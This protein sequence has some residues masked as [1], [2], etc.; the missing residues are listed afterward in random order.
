M[1]EKAL[2]EMDDDALT[3]RGMT[4][5]SFAEDCHE[6]VVPGTSYCEKHAHLEMPKPQPREKDAKGMPIT[7][8]QRRAKIREKAEKFVSEGDMVR[9]QMLTDTLESVKPKDGEYTIVKRELNDGTT[10]YI[11][12]IKLSDVKSRPMKWVW[13][14]RI[15]QGKGVVI[16]GQP[17][18]G[19]SMAV[20]DFM[21]RIT[22]GDDWPDGAKNE[23]GAKYVVWA[24][25]EDD[26]ED[27]VK[28]R[29][30]ALGADMS[31]ITAIKR[32]VTS[33]GTLHARRL[34]LK[35]DI[36]TLYK[37]LNENPDI[38][39][40]V[41][42]P[43]TGFYGG[44][45]GNSS[46]EIRPIMEQL[47]EVCRNT[48]VTIMAIMHE[49]RRKDVSAMERILGSGAVGQVFRAAFRFSADP[50]NKGGYIMA[51]SKTNYKVKGGLRYTIQDC[52]VKLDTGEEVTDIGKVVWGEQHELS[53]DDVLQQATEEAQASSAGEDLTFVQKAKLIF[54]AE[55]N[56]GR[57]P[58]R[59]IHAIFD[60]EGIDANVRKRA[61]WE[62]GVVTIG[63]A[64]G[65]Y[66]WAL[67]GKDH[68]I[69]H[70]PEVKI[71][72]P[73]LDEEL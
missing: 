57:R 52:G 55:L 11:V 71:P 41:F 22:K 46:K 1:S 28:P 29:L 70:P 35:N 8:N 43:I 62:L 37:M 14:G 6:P 2:R 50:K 26:L 47:A 36:K 34:L 63:K 69:E 72:A 68:E 4:C 45:D 7:N 65:P 42:D 27:T 21:A 23:L 60:R 49:N 73:S 24:G 54:E 64:P 18:N 5:V 3:S 30:Q 48:G 38:A 40:V 16:Q 13:Y 25:T 66:W 51:V 15:P 10:D 56:K 67:P 61:R 59:E 19:K 20:L 17:G 32:V 44:A 58:C 53:A 12:G 33:E 9:E 39:L 31:K